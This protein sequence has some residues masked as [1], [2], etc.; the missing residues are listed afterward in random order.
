MCQVH[1]GAYVSL[2]ALEKTDYVACHP[3]KTTTYI[4]QVVSVTTHTHNRRK[5]I[6]KKKQRTKKRKERKWVHG[7]QKKKKKIIF[8]G[9]TG[10]SAT[11]TGC[12]VVF[13]RSTAVQ[14]TTS[15][16]PTEA[17]TTGK[18]HDRQLAVV[19]T[20][21]CVGGPCALPLV[22][23]CLGKTCGVLDGLT[24]AAH[25]TVRLFDVSFLQ[26]MYFFFFINM[27]I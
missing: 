19:V 5:S 16:T 15:D 12:H 4:L 3:R 1:S 14:R 21:L 7:A 2:L 25:Q 22:G 10:E 17:R 8:G 26:E 13:R 20:C 27:E 6:G 23:S 9:S 18:L 11:R 24:A